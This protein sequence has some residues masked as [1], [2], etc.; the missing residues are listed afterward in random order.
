MPI[1]PP[2]PPDDPWT[3]LD[4]PTPS[5]PGPRPATPAALHAWART[6][7]GVSVPD[8]ALLPGHQAPFDYLCHAFFEDREPRDCVVWANRGGGKTFL[9][10]LATVL[11]LVFKPGI[12]IRIL[13]GSLEQAGRMHAYLRAM[14]AHEELARLV[15]GRITD[16]RVQLDNGSGCELLAQSQTSV[17]GVRVQKLR[18]D[19]VELFDER[20]WDAAQL[21]TREKR[22]G[23]VLVPGSIECLST[24][25]LPYGIMH[26]LV[27][28]PARRLFRWGVVDVL[29]TCGPRHACDACPLEP[30]CAG[31]A[32]RR[33]ASGAHA[34]HLSVDDA[35]RLKTRVGRTTWESEML[36]QR[37]RR[38]DCVLPE[39]DARTHVVHGPPPGCQS[40]RPGWTWIGGMDF[41]IRSPTV[42]LW[43]CV[44]SRGVMTVV[45]ERVVRDEPLRA[46]VEAIRSSSWPELRWLGVDPAG[47][48]RALQTGASDVEALTRAGLAV[49]AVRRPRRDGLDLIRARLRPATG[50]PRIF[51]H[52]RCARLIESL[53]RYH[54]PPERPESVEPVK[55]GAD[56]AVDALRYMVL[57]LD[58]AHRAACASYLGRREP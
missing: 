11:D 31:R 2:I 34:G 13:A 42:V 41:G 33:D 35:I 51:F 1:P 50:A 40:G 25:H 10:A 7:L 49:R 26:R 36:C 5:F 29:G 30:E 48:G 17:R 52:R 58:G 12:E 21:T 27:H 4:R 53:E 15:R 55:D 45:D 23:D 56:H 28:D 39:F 14:F 3:D 46:H 38:T 54:Y 37:P 9:A 22:C 6:W 44:D 18:C 57:G 8:A 43:A 24:M 47:H 19:E 16:R 20:L 32:K